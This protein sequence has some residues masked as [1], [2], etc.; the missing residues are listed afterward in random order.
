MACSGAAQVEAKARQPAEQ[1]HHCQPQLLE[2][3]IAGIKP[4]FGIIKKR[5]LLQR[6]RAGNIIQCS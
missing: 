3:G 4:A 1:G 2:T 5:G 6:A